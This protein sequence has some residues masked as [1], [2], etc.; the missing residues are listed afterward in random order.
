MIF[1]RRNAA[2][3][4]WAGFA[5]IF[6]ALVLFNYMI[7]FEHDFLEDMKDRDF[8]NYW[9]AGHLVREKNEMLL[10]SDLQTYAAEL[11]RRTGPL[12]QQRYWSYPPHFL[13]FTAPLGYL[14]YY[15]AL[16]AFLAWGAA[17]F[18]MSSRIFLRGLSPGK[19]ALLAPFIMCNAV[20]AQN[21][22]LTGG[23]FLLALGW[24]EERPVLS[25]IALGLLTIKPHLGVLLPILFLF[26]RRYAAIASAIV[27]TVLLVLAS[28]LIFGQ[29]TWLAYFEQTVP[30]MKIVMNEW[31][32]LFLYL[33]P[34]L[35]GS[36][37]ALKTEPETALVFQLLFAVIALVISAPS[38]FRT[39]SADTRS[40]IVIIATFLVLPYQYV[41]DTGPLAAAAALALNAGSL[42]RTKTLAAAAALLPLGTVAIGMLASPLA[43]VLI[44]ALL[45]AVMIYE[46]AFRARRQVKLGSSHIV[47]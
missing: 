46:P 29:E 12:I 24:R 38:F 30:Y 20:T 13:F 44:L 28:I 6:L 10:F 42:V 27:T 31:N 19:L 47:I 15:P 41:Y 22:F 7:F 39:G 23:L 33:M 14:S 2:A 26:E 34:S 21:G 3:F 4:G 5:L 40:L 37:R 43:P 8:V 45:L 18:A 35:F 9:M 32:G 36:L 11:S 25:G 16:A 1:L 17:F